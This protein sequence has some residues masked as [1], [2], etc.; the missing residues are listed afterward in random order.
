MTTKFCPYCKCMMQS[1]GYCRNRDCVLGSKHQ[2]TVPQLEK[3]HQ[4]CQE[5]NIDISGK[6]H[7][8]L[9]KQKATELITK[10]I[11]RKVNNELCEEDTDL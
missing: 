9:T 1:N 7:N 3:I 10:L 5:L 6:D 11:K 8:K 4:L 2:A